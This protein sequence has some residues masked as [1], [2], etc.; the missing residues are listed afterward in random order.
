MAYLSLLLLFFFF[1]TNEHS[2]LTLNILT[3][4][5]LVRTV[6]D[7]T[8]SYPGVCSHGAHIGKCSSPAQTPPLEYSQYTIGKL[9]QKS[10]KQNKSTFTIMTITQF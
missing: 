3:F 9:H 4:Y 7:K 8:I 1:I 6:G 10:S 2:A 5:T